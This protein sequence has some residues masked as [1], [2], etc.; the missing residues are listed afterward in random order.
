MLP[1]LADNLQCQTGA[2]ISELPSSPFGI[3]WYN[4]RDLIIPDCNQLP[5][6]YWK[7]V[8]TQ[9]IFITRERNILGY[10]WEISEIRINKRSRETAREK[11]LCVVVWVEHFCYKFEACI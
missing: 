11:E 2:A 9:E 6:S 8:F 10:F 7:K 5:S 3:K 1:W 4:S